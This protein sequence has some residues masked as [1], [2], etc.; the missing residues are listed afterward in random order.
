MYTYLYLV[1]I[2]IY[3]EFIQRL[4]L[5]F[6]HITQV[7][8]DHLSAPLAFVAGL[9]LRKA[10]ALR[11]SLRKH[12]GFLEQRQD[13]LSLKIMGTKVYKNCAGYVILW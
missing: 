3:N 2:C 12:V 6:L 4:W 1:Y 9:G 7:A 11:Q 13:L 10:D 5:C 8:Y